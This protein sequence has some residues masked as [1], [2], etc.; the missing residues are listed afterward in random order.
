MA[1]PP[2]LHPNEL[3]VQPNVVAVFNAPYGQNPITISVFN[4]LPKPV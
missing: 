4:R 2:T 3:A 1:G